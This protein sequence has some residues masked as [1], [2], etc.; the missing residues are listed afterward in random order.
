[1]VETFAHFGIMVFIFLYMHI[2]FVFRNNATFTDFS[3]RKHVWNEYETNL[4][5]IIYLERINLYIIGTMCSILAAS[6]L[7]Q[8]IDATFWLHFDEHLMI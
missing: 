5:V 2:V 1:M 6:F 8:Q 3:T 4:K 7:L